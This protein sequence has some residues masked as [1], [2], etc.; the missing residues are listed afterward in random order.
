MW[1]LMMTQMREE[2]GL[3]LVY[4]DEVI[5]TKR[6]ST[7]IAVDW[8]VERVQG[9]LDTVRRTGQASIVMLS[10][11]PSQHSLFSPSNYA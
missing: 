10:S 11:S 6:L 3:T 9:L 7:R 2:L 4:C 5:E 8:N 1:S